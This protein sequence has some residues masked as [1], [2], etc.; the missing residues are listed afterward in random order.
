MNSYI[1]PINSC[2]RSWF[3]FTVW[4]RGP[5][6]NE[7]KASCLGSIWRII[8]EISFLAMKFSS[9]IDQYCYCHPWTYVKRPIP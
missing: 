7:D 2:A 5:D 8:A 9:T 4:A 1:P 6:E 3:E